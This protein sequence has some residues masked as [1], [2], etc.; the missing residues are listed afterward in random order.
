MKKEI[1]E[2]EKKWFWKMEYCRKHR[3]PPAQSWAWWEAEQA[4]KEYKESQKKGK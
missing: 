2:H 1:T 4:W 3:L